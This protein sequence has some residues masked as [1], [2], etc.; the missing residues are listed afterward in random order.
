[1][2]IE[3]SCPVFQSLRIAFE[4]LRS[5]LVDI[6]G[7]REIS[8][9]KAQNRELLARSLKG[10]EVREE[11]GFYQA[12]AETT[13][14]L[15][16]YWMFQKKKKRTQVKKDV[17]AASSVTL[18]RQERWRHFGLRHP[19]FFVKMLNLPKAHVTGLGTFLASNVDS[20]LT[21]IMQIRPSDIW[22]SLE[23]LPAHIAAARHSQDSLD[24]LKQVLNCGP[25]GVRARDHLGRLPLHIASQNEDSTAEDIVEELLELYPLAV[26]A[27][28]HSGMLPLHHAAMNSGPCASGMAGRLISAFACGAQTVD[29]FGRL[30]IDYC[31]MS[32]SENVTELIKA[33]SRAF[34][35]GCRVQDLD[36]DNILHRI[37]RRICIDEAPGAMDILRALLEVRIRPN[38]CSLHNCQQELPMHIIATCTKRRGAE[39]VNLLAEAYLPAC[40]AQVV[41]LSFRDVV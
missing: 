38:L 23:R 17:E 3:N 28:D 9:A 5:R 4:A 34:V 31:L 15:S 14:I 25:H 36:G 30:P 35:P 37:C 27:Q 13:M 39:A 2:S 19:H 12:E 33:V 26:H 32:S 1:L 7:G 22:S 41:N 20:W 11:Y 6:Y 24:V 40:W 18:K 10:T 8:A 29:D 16:R 21:K